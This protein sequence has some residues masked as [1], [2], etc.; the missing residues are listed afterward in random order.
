[1]LRLYAACYRAYKAVFQQH[2][3]TASVSQSGHKTPVA[4]DNDATLLGDAYR[5]SG[6]LVG[7]LGALIIFCAVAP[8][9]FGIGGK[10][11]AQLFGIAEL[12]LMLW[13]IQTIVYVRT[14]AK[15]KEDL[16]S[17]WLEARSV[18]ELARYKPLED[19]TSGSLPEIRSVVEPLLGFPASSNDD[20]IAYNRRSAERYHAIE[21]AAERATWAGFAISLAAAATHL[22]FHLDALIFLTAFLPA[23]VGALH[24]INAFLRLE[25]LSEDHHRMAEALKTLRDEFLGAVAADDLDRVRELAQRIHELLGTGHLGWREIATKL[26]VKAP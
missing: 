11:I 21:H 12:L 18:A 25:L 23:A 16:K 10:A 3:E 13:V 26:E 17:R 1:M 7:I 19:I 20:Q 9:G 22:L 5:G 24:G 2:A 14:G 4:P 8:F 6:V 15:T